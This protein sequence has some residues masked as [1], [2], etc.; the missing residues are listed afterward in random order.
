[1]DD[2]VEREIVDLLRDSEHEIDVLSFA[3][4]D[5]PIA[6]ISAG[7]SSL[8]E[9]LRE[10]DAVFVRRHGQDDPVVVV[11]WKAFGAIAAAFD[12]LLGEEKP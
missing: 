9:W 11:P 3:C 4:D 1:V 5:K 8:L 6:S 10:N 12:I 2:Q 7:F